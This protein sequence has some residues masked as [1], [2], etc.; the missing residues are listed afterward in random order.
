[1]FNGNHCLGRPSKWGN[2][3]SH[4]PWSKAQFRTSCKAESLVKHR[5]WI[6]KSPE[7]IQAIKTELRGKILGCWCDNPYACH[8][9]ILWIVANDIT[10]LETSIQQP[11]LF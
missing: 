5:E 6:L 4:K 1:M 11:T 7:F 10:E 2:P 3:F 8:G 9:Y